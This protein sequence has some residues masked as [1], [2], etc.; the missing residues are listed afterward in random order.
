MTC[1]CAGL[2]GLALLAVAATGRAEEGRLGDLDQK[3]VNGAASGG[4]YEV[5]SSELAADRA[6]D[7][8]TKKFAKHM[9][10][11]HSK[12]NKELMSLLDKRKA[13]PPKDM[14][15]QERANVDKLTKLKGA[16]FDREYW[17]QQLAAHKEA[18]ALFEEEAKNGKD[19]DLKAFAE[20]TL[21]TIRDHLKMAQE[22]TRP[23]RSK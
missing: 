13:T 7:E 18:V 14:R 5:K 16:D 3:F 1:V 12:A 17:M 20:K 23:D 21:P 2:T 22:H 4:Q 11:D 10:D 8:G 9:I 6:A 15:E 19:A